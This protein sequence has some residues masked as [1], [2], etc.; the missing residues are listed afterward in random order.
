[1]IDGL[2]MIQSPPRKR[3]AR[4]ASMGLYTGAA[5]SKMMDVMQAAISESTGKPCKLSSTDG[6]GYSGG[7]GAATGAVKDTSTGTK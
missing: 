4:K 3:G 5:G 6:G 1:M 2:S 7:G